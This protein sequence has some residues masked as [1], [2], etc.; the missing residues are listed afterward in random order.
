LGLAYLV[1]Q[2]DSTVRAYPDRTE[3][4][5]RERDAL[6]R[7]WAM[8]RG[9]PTGQLDLA[10]ADVRV[11]LTAFIVDLDVWLTDTGLGSSS[12]QT[13]ESSGQEGRT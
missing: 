4:Q 2:L 3:A 1:S 7:R 5:R 9:L 13:T 10:V 11:F 6:L 8:L 12:E